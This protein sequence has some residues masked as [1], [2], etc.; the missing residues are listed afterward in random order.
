MYKHGERAQDLS[1]RD[2][3]KLYSKHVYWIRAEQF[4]RRA[5]LR[6]VIYTRPTLAAL[7]LVAKFNTLY[8]YISHISAYGEHC[9]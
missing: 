5:E 2:K 6:T 1:S 7:Q 9:R 4:S 3:I 8:R